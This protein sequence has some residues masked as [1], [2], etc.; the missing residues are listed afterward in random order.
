MS[1]KLDWEHVE[2]R[3]GLLEEILAMLAFAHHND[4]VEEEESASVPV[5]EAGPHV[6]LCHLTGTH[7]KHKVA[8]RH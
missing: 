7:T 3:E 6:Q 1:L 5:S 4:V 8:M 2:E